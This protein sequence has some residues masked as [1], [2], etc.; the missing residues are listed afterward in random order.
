VKRSDPTKASDEG[1]FG[2]N[3]TRHT[4]QIEWMFISS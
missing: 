3:H 1:S 4:Q 2:P